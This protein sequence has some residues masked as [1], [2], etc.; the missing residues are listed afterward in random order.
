MAK[1]AKEECIYICIVC[2][3]KNNPCKHTSVGTNASFTPTLCP[4]DKNA[5]A[6][7]KGVK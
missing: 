5:E 2:F 6:V 3:G 4:Y 7:W 1:K